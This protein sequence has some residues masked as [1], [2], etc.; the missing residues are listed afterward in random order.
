MMRIATNTRCDSV[1]SEVRL[2]RLLGVDVVLVQW[3]IF[4]YIHHNFGSVD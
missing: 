1:G 2:L 4:I 3:N